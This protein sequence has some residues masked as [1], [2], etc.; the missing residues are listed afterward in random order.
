MVRFGQ[1]IKGVPESRKFS[2]ANPHDHGV[3][4]EGLPFGLC[5]I[6]IATILAQ[7]QR[8][9]IEKLIA[10]S[11]TD[12]GLI[13]YTILYHYIRSQLDP[14]WLWWIQWKPHPKSLSDPAGC[15]P[16]AR[17]FREEEKIG[18]CRQTAS[19]PFSPLLQTSPEQSYL[20]Q[21][22]LAQIPNSEAVESSCL[23]CWARQKTTAGSRSDKISPHPRCRSLFVCT[24]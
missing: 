23:A 19:P 21:H 20:H 12:S 22:M 1:G 24:H 2:M 11:I 9:Q 17:R 16:T 10:S 8:N 5:D 18:L 3:P 13:S 15:H 4:K 6:L 14:I 7:N